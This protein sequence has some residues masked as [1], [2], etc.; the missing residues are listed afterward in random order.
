MAFDYVP[1][2]ESTALVE[3]R[4]EYGLF[5]AGDFHTGAALSP[6]VNPA[7]GEVLAQ[8][9]V[10]GPEQVDAGVAAARLAFDEVWGPMPPAERA[11]YLYRLATLVG[12]HSRELALLEALDTG[13]PIRHI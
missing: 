4:S 11:R 5:V 13:K 7:N 9:A 2:P 10:A 6:T 3:L 1:A 8:V 12:Q